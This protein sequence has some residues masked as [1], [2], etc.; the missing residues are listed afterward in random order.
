MPFLKHRKIR[1]APGLADDVRVLRSTEVN[2]M[3]QAAKEFLGIHPNDAEVLV[4]EVDPIQ[5]SLARD[6]PIKFLPL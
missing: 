6:P 1:G 5:V 3:I 4:G 2:S